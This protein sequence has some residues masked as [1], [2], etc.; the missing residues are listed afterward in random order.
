MK[1]RNDECGNS[2]KTN[3]KWRK[4]HLLKVYRAPPRHA[5]WERA[6]PNTSLGRRQTTN[7]RSQ[8]SG[9]SSHSDAVGIPVTLIHQEV[10]VPAEMIQKDAETPFELIETSGGIIHNILDSVSITV[11]QMMEKEM[12][13]LIEVLNN[14]H[15]NESRLRFLKREVLR[16]TALEHRTR[17]L[18][19]HEEMGL[20]NL[21]MFIV[22][23]LR[24][25]KH[26]YEL[27]GVVKDAIEKI[28]ERMKVSSKLRKTFESKRLQRL[29]KRIVNELAIIQQ[30]ITGGIVYERLRSLRLRVAEF[31]DTASQEADPQ[32][33]FALNLGHQAA[34]GL[35]GLIKTE[36]GVR[37][38]EKALYNSLQK[39]L[40]HVKRAKVLAGKLLAEE[41]EQK[42][43]VEKKCAE[44]LEESTWH[45]VWG[46]EH[47]RGM[48]E[49]MFKAKGSTPRS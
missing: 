40:R 38:D 44:E 36:R 12:G 17:M 32:K 11:Q 3:A 46:R 29:R 28:E 21:A 25:Q 39:L 2:Q 19:E 34:K 47:Y 26:C 48:K 42:E 20:S 18:L 49:E 15:E 16:D 24:K 8:R 9:G 23:V 45:G 43:K 10:L 1:S 33:H 35:K 14:T 37:G 27:T 4:E 30:M 5:G 7:T 22:E 13:R 41:R 6:E 31:K